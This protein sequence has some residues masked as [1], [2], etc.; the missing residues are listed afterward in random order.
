MTA[1]LLLARH[2]ETPS[3]LKHALDS[4]PPGP[5]LT[6]MGQRQANALAD[7]LAEDQVV[8]VYASV[9]VRAQQTAEP[10]AKRH[11]LSVDVVEGLHELQV[12]DLEGRSDE[13][14]LRSFGEVYTRWTQGDL[15]AAMPGGESGEEIRGRYLATI[16]RI[17]ANH[18]SGLIV[19]VSHGGIIRLG[20]EWLADNVGAQL[21]NAKLLPN[22]GH[23]LLEPRPTG[24]HC[25]EWTGVDL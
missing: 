23:V 1:R 7:R 5:P 18:P 22:T 19:V 13:A 4:R 9:A 21:A 12:G 2:G 17:R 6:D 8:A 3:N 20:A 25:L 10:V 16:E 24:W 14:A 11:G 15:A